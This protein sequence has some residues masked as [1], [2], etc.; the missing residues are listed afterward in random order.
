[1]LEEWGGLVAAAALLALLAGLLGARRAGAEGERQ[2]PRAPARARDGAEAAES[3][4]ARQRPREGGRSAAAA[5]ALLRVVRDQFERGH[6]EAAVAHW[7]ALGAAGLEAHAEPAIAIRM[8][9]LLRDEGRGAEAAA[10][11]RGALLRSEGPTGGPIAARVARV[12]ADVDPGLAVDAASRALASP[13][14]GPLDR[15]DLERLLARLK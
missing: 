12:A 4:A 7:L 11:L 13:E 3:D 10:A 8:A 5:E 15:L 9:T 6:K 2:I 1:M 14:L